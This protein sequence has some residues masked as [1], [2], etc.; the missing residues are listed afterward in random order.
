MKTART[1][2]ARKRVQHAPAGF[3]KVQRR[4]GV[5]KQ[6][7]RL[8]VWKNEILAR[9][10]LAVLDQARGIKQ[11]LL[12]AARLRRRFGHDQ[13]RLAGTGLSLGLAQMM[14]QEHDRA[15]AQIGQ[16]RRLLARELS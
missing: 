11:K 13:Q 3:D 2:P 12:Q 15:G 5:L 6:V 7:L 9:M 10:W 16:P 4:A 14:Q 8:E 1:V